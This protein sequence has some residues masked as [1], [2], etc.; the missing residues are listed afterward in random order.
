LKICA[1]Y[2]VKHPRDLRKPKKS[3]MKKKIYLSG[4]LFLSL[5]FASIANKVKSDDS[6]VKKGVVLSVDVDGLGG[7]LKDLESGHIREFKGATVTIEKG[8]DVIYINIVTPLGQ[9]ISII[10]TDENGA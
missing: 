7:T 1:W 9:E 6:G 3:L 10:A 5:N 8:E 2:F 4:L